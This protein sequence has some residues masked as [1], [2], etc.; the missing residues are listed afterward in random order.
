MVKP[1]FV[2]AS[3]RAMPTWDGQAAPTGLKETPYSHRGKK[4]SGKLFMQKAVDRV[5]GVPRAAAQS[6]S[7]TESKNSKLEQEFGKERSMGKGF[8]VVAC[9]GK[10]RP[11]MFSTG[12]QRQ[13][14][15]LTSSFQHLISSQAGKSLLSAQGSAS[16]GRNGMAKGRKEIQTNQQEVY[17][18]VNP[19]ICVL[20]VHQGHNLFC[21]E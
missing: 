14:N 18:K 21:D 6:L 12:M 20:A 1:W 10:Y 17:G 15:S 3:V 16:W 19:E 4:F 13:I 8:E 5:Q 9:V 11:S 7:Q 2:Y